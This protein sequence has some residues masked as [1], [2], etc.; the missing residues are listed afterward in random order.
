M[1]LETLNSPEPPGELR[2]RFFGLACYFLENG[3]VIREGDTIDEDA[4]ERIKVIY[5]RSSF[6]HQGLMRLDYSSTAAAKSP[7]WK[8]W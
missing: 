4:H 1:E 2:E 7:W 6:G 3:P 5:A 8:F